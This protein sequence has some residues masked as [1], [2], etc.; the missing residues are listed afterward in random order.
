MQIDKIEELIRQGYID[1]E[2][3]AKTS[4][5]R[6]TV[7]KIRRSMESAKGGKEGAK[8][9]E[10]ET[11]GKETVIAIG[12]GKDNEKVE[13]LDLQGKKIRF[14]DVVDELLVKIAQ[15]PLEKAKLNSVLFEMLEEELQ[16]LRDAFLLTMSARLVEEF[17]CNA[18]GSE[19]SVVPIRCAKCGKDFL[20][21]SKP[22]YI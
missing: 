8:S 9:V 22:E 6:P 7:R 17:I 4:V 3:C 15:F 20:W 5:S 16:N 19:K 14:S 12:E 10:N 2:I 21:G 11:I 13:F 1:V 18:C